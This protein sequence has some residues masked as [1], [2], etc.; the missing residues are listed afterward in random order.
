MD[1]HPV[2]DH[3]R[4]YFLIYVSYI[5]ILRPKGRHHCHLPPGPISPYG[6]HPLRHEGYALYVH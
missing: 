4:L 6:S 5:R 1:Y 3:T 2:R